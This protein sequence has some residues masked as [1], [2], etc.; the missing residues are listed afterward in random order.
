MV[1]FQPEGGSRNFL[2]LSI[3]GAAPPGKL[4]GQGCADRL[5]VG[6]GALSFPEIDCDRIVKTAEWKFF[7]ITLMIGA[8]ELLCAKRR[9]SPKAP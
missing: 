7:L 5:G 4:K 3:F 8:E 6:Q 1:G 9:S 2:V